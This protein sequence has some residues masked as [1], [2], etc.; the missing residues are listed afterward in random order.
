MVR[1]ENVTLH[2]SADR[3][4]A[5]R[6]RYHAKPLPCRVRETAGGEAELDL[7]EG[8][9]AVAPGQLA[10]LMHDDYVVGEGTIGGSG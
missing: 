6:L 5:V 8:A 7:H 2:R 3:V 4:Q 1:L 10:C 9:S